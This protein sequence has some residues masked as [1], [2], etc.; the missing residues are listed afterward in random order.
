MAETHVSLDAKLATRARELGC[1]LH[2]VCEVALMEAIWG[3]RA[4][5]A[6]DVSRGRDGV[7]ASG[8]EP[9]LSGSHPLVRR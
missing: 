9:G 5:K 3:E 4:A 6:L 8:E 1:D 7:W 2:S